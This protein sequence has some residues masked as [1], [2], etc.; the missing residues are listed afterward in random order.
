MY[1]CMYV[2]MYV[3][4]YVPMYVCMYVPMYDQI[5]SYFCGGIFLFMKNLNKVSRVCY[6]KNCF[7]T[8]VRYGTVRYFTFYKICGANCEPM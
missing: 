6:L 5:I 1:V 2:P 4:M 7:I 3:C 8:K